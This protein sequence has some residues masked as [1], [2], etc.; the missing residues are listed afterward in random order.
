[1]VDQFCKDAPYS[2]KKCLRRRKRNG[3][4][5][6]NCETSFPTMTRDKKDT[7]QAEQIFQENFTVVV[8]EDVEAM[9]NFVPKKRKQV[10][11]EKI[12]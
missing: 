5:P 4:Q 8:K 7:K 3:S 12:E 6:S 1:M 10:A 11:K 2:N 9:E